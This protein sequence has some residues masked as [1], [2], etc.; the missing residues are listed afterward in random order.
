MASDTGTHEATIEARFETQ[1]EAAY[2]SRL[3][4]NHVEWPGMS[5]TPPDDVWARCTVLWGDGFERTLGATTVGKNVLIGVLVVQ[6]FD[7]PGK[8]Y[9]NLDGY[10]N[11]VRDW[12]NRQELTNNVR[13]GAAGPPQK[14]EAGD[15]WLQVNIRMPFE[16]EETY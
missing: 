14:V 15:G 4:K 13:F 8:G 2:P 16:V 3:A 11:N 5:L 12:F 7:K 6:L 10:V 9:G 1:W